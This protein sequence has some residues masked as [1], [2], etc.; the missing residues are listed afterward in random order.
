MKKKTLNLPALLLTC[1]LLLAAGQPFLSF[2][3]FLNQAGSDKRKQTET[4]LLDVYKHAPKASSAGGEEK[5]ADQPAAAA[6]QE[7]LMTY[8]PATGTIPRER[9][10]QAYRETKARQEMKSSSSITWQG[11]GVEMGGRARM[12]MYDPNDINH[13]KVWAGGV[14]GGLW[15]NT[16][17]TNPVSSWI[18]VGD[19]WPTLS[20]RCMTY[21]PN[22]S[23]VFYIGTGEPETALITYRESSGVGQGIWKS[24]DGGQTWSQLLSTV[25]FVYITDI[26]V[27]NENGTS[28]IY[29]GVVSGMYH[30]IHQS[31]PTDGL[32][33]SADGGNTWTQVLPVIFG[34]AVP[35]APSDIDEGPDGRIFVGT[36][37]NLEGGG[38][39][40]LLYSD[41]GLPGSW[42]V[43]EDYRTLIENDP[44]YPIP[45]R[46]VL[47]TAKSDPNVVYALIASG[48]VNP[49][50]SFTYYY[51]FHI[52]RSDDKGSSWTMKNLP[53]NLTSGNNFA[54]IAWHAL[55]IG[56]DPANP[57]NLYIGGLDVHHS[58]NGGNSWMRV[59]DWSKMYSGG[60][61]DYIHADQHCIVYKPG[62]SSEILFGTDGGVF[63]TGNG[64]VNYPAFEQRNADFNTLQF[65]TCAIH[66]DAGTIS[67]LGGLQDNGSLHY[68]GNP[69][70]IDDMWS[71]GDGAYCFYDENDGSLSVTSVYYNQ[72]YIFMNGSW[73]NS[74]YN[75]SSGV[76]ISPA[77]FDYRKNAIYANAVDFVGNYADH[78]L[79][80]T[81]IT[82]AGSG[83][84]LNIN[85][86]SNLYFSAVTY[87]PHSTNSQANLFIGNQEGRVF[88]VENA[89]AA[90]TVTEIGSTDFPPAN[91]SSIGVGGSEDTLAVTFSNYGVPSVWVTTNGGQTWT[92]VESNLP[93]MPIRWA[94]VHPSSSKHVLLATETGVWRT[95][96]L[97]AIPVSW[98]PV[99]NGMANVRVDM[100]RFR[101]SDNTVLAGTHGRGFF[102]AT[103]DVA[104]GVDGQELPALAVCPNPASGQVT[105]S[106]PA[107][108]LSRVSV[109]LINTSG[110]VVFQETDQATGQF[111]KSIDLTLL[112]KG[113]YFLVLEINGKRAGTE[114]LVVF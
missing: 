51:C 52:L 91:V 59:S 98:E 70:T 49:A 2:I 11:T 46:V 41:S 34:S 57:N 96:N 83:T 8:D 64:I 61:Y 109:R 72:Y 103:W 20:I 77:D 38:A 53:T 92:D 13:K 3:S 7:F 42:V 24:A 9:L 4:F 75:W 60:G 107:P 69:L 58:T 97:Y 16:D 112:A 40:T 17:I 6:F 113:S 80:L 108:G 36:R 67:Y 71:G 18:P 79:R 50:N 110:R 26:L 111:R 23:Q 84:Y 1:I 25:N 102:T 114:K 15:Y 76:F 19:F 31:L 29:A 32:Y 30:G 86:G 105:V 12:I 65:Y 54:T 21:D 68:S 27:R 78:I 73:I 28:V 85:S 100:L 47:A 56:V 35:Y 14:T 33:R 106:C 81:N 104:V 89:N 95:E 10:L 74:L 94:L 63:Y 45:G 66:P 101:K 99:N 90:H 22:N 44:D 48:Y 43:N 88:K 82:G 5:P 93:D 55:D 37:P 39:A 62:S 87:S